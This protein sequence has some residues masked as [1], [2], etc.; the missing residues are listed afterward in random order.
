MNCNLTVVV[1]THNPD[2]GRLARTLQALR[3]QTLS[4][5]RWECLIVDN[6]SNP[7][8]QLTDLSGHGPRGLRL[9]AE[10]VPGLSQARRRG[11]VSSSGDI[12]VLV[13]DDN[14]LSADYL[15]EV[16]RFFAAHPKVGVLGGRSLP[17]FEIPPPPWVREFDGLLALRDLGEE[18]LV[19]TGL[20]NPAT[21]RNDYPAFAPIGA[22]LAMRRGVAQCWLERGSHAV[23][24][25]RQGGKLSSGGD[26]D[27]VLCAMTSGWEAAY[28]PALRLTHL[29]P[30]S[31]I[32]PGYLG[33]L[34]RGIQESWMQVLALHDANPWPPLSP[35]GST[36][37]QWRAWFT[38]RAWSSPAAQIRWQGACGH[39]AG[40]VAR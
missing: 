7:S 15:A 5:D 2:S 26:N 10:P 29:I 9:V 35:L 39:F 31:R 17:E 30:R 3:A 23:L 38:H 12:I 16:L 28:D 11:F 36:L 14:E 33:R 27:L 34:N 1:P 21:G 8:L 25:D 6:A 19:S 4:T 40:R 32:T 20:R 18:P 37:R 13:D 22:G 24:P